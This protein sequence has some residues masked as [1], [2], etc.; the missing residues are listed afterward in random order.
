MND[1]LLALLRASRHN[2]VGRLARDPEIKY[3]DSGNSVCN[4]RILINKPGAK[5]DDGQ[6]PDG[7]NLAIWGE[8]GVAFADQCRKG[9]LVEVVGRVK[10]DSWTDRNTAETRM[11]W[12]VTV[13]RWAP[14]AS[15]APGPAPAA[16]PAAPAPRPAAAAQATPSWASAAPAMDDNDIP[17]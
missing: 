2:F 12:T 15:G 7:F 14:V 1:H 10:T 3:L 13:D 8:Q 6:Q 17:F 11:A 16:A 9:Q 5:R 4:A